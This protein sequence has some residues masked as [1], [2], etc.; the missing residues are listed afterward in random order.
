MPVADPW[1]LALFL[2]LAVAPAGAALAR[3]GLRL[4][5]ALLGALLGA[6]AGAAAL[7]LEPAGDWLALA[8][9]AATAGALVAVLLPGLGLARFDRRTFGAA[10][11]RLHAGGHGE[12]RLPARCAGLRPSRLLDPADRLRLESALCEAEEKGGTALAVV[13]VRR[14]GEY[15]GAAWRAAAWLA[16][17]GLAGATA[18]GLPSRTALAAAAGGACLGHLLARVARVRRGFVAEGEL[19]ERARQAAAAAFTAAGLGGSGALVFAALFEGRV[20]ALGSQRD[21]GGHFD[22]MASAAAAGLAG[23]DALR[24][25]E[26]ALRGAPPRTAGA[27]PVP[28]PA[29]PH[30]I[31]V[32]D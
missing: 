19:A 12:A 8:A 16:A 30:P 29:R 13:L 26:D 27:E 1:P 23:G 25:F 32:E 14:C 2:G 21:A 17:L 9:R 22:A 10:L 4:R 3:R 20:V 31:R 6:L 5:G 7:P 15:E 18:L 24:A 11:E 28:L